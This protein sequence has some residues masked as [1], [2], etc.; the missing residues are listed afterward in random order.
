MK[1]NENNSDI[2]VVKLHGVAEVM[3]ESKNLAAKRAQSSG[4]MEANGGAGRPRNPTP[5]LT[6]TQQE[7]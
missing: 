7:T 6:T 4:G 2:L 5:T 1:T 3:N